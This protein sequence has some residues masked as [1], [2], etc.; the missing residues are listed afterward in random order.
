[1]KFVMRGGAG[2]KI[3]SSSTTTPL[4]CSKGSR[5]GPGPGQ[6]AGR[7]HN[8]LRRDTSLCRSRPNYFRPHC[9]FAMSG[10]PSVLLCREITAGRFIGRHPRSVS[11]RL[12]IRGRTRGRT[13]GSFVRRGFRAQP[14]A[15]VTEHLRI[16]LEGDRAGAS[17]VVDSERRPEARVTEHQRI[18]R[19]G[20]AGRRP[21]LLNP[22]GSD[23]RATRAEARV[24]EHQ[25]IRPRGRAGASAALHGV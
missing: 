4:I 9:L 13:R 12:R 25:P 16:G 5:I 14:E 21:A 1:M 6:A 2:C 19:G 24:T 8:V 17:F 3:V 23:S 10:P 20:R 7:Y 11:E 15:R 22:S 18:R